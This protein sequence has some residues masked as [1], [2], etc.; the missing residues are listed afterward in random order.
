MNWICWVSTAVFFNLFAFFFNIPPVLFL[1]QGHRGQLRS[2]WKVLYRRGKLLEI[3]SLLNKGE[4]ET[5]LCLA[6]SLSGSPSKSSSNM[7][8]TYTE[9][10]HNQRSAFETHRNPHREH[11]P[12]SASCGYNHTSHLHMAGSILG[13][14]LSVWLS[15]ACD[16]EWKCRSSLYIWAKAIRL[17]TDSVISPSLEGGCITLWARENINWSE[18]MTK[19][20][21][22]E[23]GVRR[24]GK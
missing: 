18:C 23:K 13:S 16:A 6:H 7:L 15:T 12:M 2:V 17:S 14:S 3:T 10:W 24:E 20:P 1:S 21:V 5:D 19:K 9:T 8:T 22:G 4:Q 11:T